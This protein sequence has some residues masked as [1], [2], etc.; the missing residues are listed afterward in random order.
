M[1]EWQRYEGTPQRELFRQLRERFLVRHA[2]PQGWTLDVGCGPGRFSAWVG[3]PACRRVGIDLSADALRLGHELALSRPGSSE[4]GVRLV[5]GDAV[6][7]PFE[8]PSFQEIVL[9]GNTLGFETRTGPRLLEAVE[10]LVGRGGKLLVEIAPG[11][12]ERSRYLSRLPAGAVR[13]LLAAPL[14]AVLPRVARE[15]FSEAA[16]PE[17]LG[18]FRRWSVDE[19]RARWSAPAWRLLE[20]I[21]VAPALG[22]DPGT[23]AEVAHDPKAW[24]RLLEVEEAVG[25]EPSRWE[26]ASA[27]LL[28]VERSSSPTKT[29]DRS[30]PSIAR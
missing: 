3:G 11:S 16:E 17:G 15:G 26:R 22:A 7:P 21:A 24:E 4:L 19:L 2:A 23:V 29:I 10:R 25:L 20:A 9:L 14:A 27:V 28:A 18:S 13:R 6:R 12:G 1:R 5:R 8:E 30:R